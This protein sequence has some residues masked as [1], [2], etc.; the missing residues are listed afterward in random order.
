MNPVIL[1]LGA[2]PIRLPVIVEMVALVAVAVV[3]VWAIGRS[4]DDRW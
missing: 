4:L 2:D 1:G 3:F